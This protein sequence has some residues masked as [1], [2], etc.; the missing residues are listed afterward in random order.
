M[1]NIHQNSIVTD[2]AK[3][4]C[5]LKKKA[6]K[7]SLRLPQTKPVLKEDGRETRGHKI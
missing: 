5:E 7:Q 3:F 1:K 6:R 4:Y 2:Q